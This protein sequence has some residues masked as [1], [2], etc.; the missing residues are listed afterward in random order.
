MTDPLDVLLNNRTLVEIRRD[1]VSRSTD[2]LDPS[3]VGLRVRAGTLKRREE[4]V[5]NIDDVAGE[6]RADLGGEDLHV[7]GKDH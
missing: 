7:A 5:V 1:V 4:G 2:E 6:P 3:I